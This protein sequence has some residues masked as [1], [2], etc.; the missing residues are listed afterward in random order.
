MAGISEKSRERVKRAVK[1]GEQVLFIQDTTSLDYS[2]HPATKGLGPMEHAKHQGMFVHTTLAISESGEVLGIVDQQVW[3]RDPDKV[4]QRHQRK[5]RPFEEKESSIWW[6]GLQGSMTDLSVS[7]VVITVADREADVYELFQ[8]AAEKQYK[9]L[10]RAAWNRRLEGEPADYLWQAVRRAP[11]PGKVQ[12]QVGRAKER[13]PREATLTVRFTQVELRPSKRSKAQRSKLTGLE[14]LQPQSVTI[15]EVIE[16]HP[17]K[18][19]EALHWLLLTNLE[20]NTLAEAQRCL[21]WYALRWVIERF[22]FVLKSGC[23]I[24]ARQLQ[25]AQR[26]M[27]C[28]AALSIVAWRI[29]W[30][31]Y[32]ARITPEAPCTV[33]LQAHEWKALFAKSNPGVHTPA[34]PPTLHQAVRWIAQLGGFL[35]RKSDGEPGVKTI[36]K[37]WQRMQ[38]L[39]EGWL[40]AYGEFRTAFPMYPGDFFAAYR[41]YLHNICV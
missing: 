29:L 21:C 36:W 28:L 22:H 23:R 38:D 4:G 16:E 35:G 24:E 15:I 9:F 2:H 20:I 8:G 7:P 10:I 19:Q 27:T 13:A 18:G 25:T 14:T 32:Q 30:L 40:L 39:A 26:L 3:T 33:V 12:V 17:P 41:F 37:G 6:S 34:K 5:E 11:V 1:K 31:T